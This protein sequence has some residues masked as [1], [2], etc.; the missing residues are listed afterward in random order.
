MLLYR[1]GSSPDDGLDGPKHTV[2]VLCNV[3]GAVLGLLP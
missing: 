2:T 1:T 3:L